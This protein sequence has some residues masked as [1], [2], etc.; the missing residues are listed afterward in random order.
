MLKFE[1]VIPGNVLYHRISF[2]GGLDIEGYDEI[3]KVKKNKLKTDTGYISR[4]LFNMFDEVKIIRDSSVEELR[5]KMK[6]QERLGKVLLEFENTTL[7]TDKNEFYSVNTYTKDNLIIIQNEDEE[8]II[9]TYDN[10]ADMVMEVGYLSLDTIESLL[11]DL[12]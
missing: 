5:E 8:F 9:A 6:Y 12:E 11:K 4:E 3:I 1:T 2:G 10:N 7:D